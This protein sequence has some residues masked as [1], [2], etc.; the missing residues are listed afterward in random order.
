M[1]RRPQPAKRSRLRWILALLAILAL[2]V[3]W[4]VWYL[5]T[6]DGLSTS[7]DTVEDAGAVGQDLY[8]GMWAVGDDFDRTIRIDEIEVPVDAD[9]DVTVTPKLCAGGTVSVTTDAASFCPE[10][11]DVDGADFE[12]GDSIVLVVNASAPTTVEIGRLEVSFHDGIRWATDDAGIAGA[13]LTFAQGTPGT[14]EEDGTTGDQ[15]TE[16]PGQD[17]STEKDKKGDRKKK[18]KGASA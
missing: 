1:P 13:T 7:A 15:P 10:L 6:P 2:V 8:V 3:A 9:A 11:E 18:D 17:D 16:R 4:V 14:V 5:K 12:A